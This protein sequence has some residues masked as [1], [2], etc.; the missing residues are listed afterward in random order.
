V[1]VPFV[2]C[3]MVTR[4]RASLARRAVACFANQTWPHRELVIVDDGDQDYRPMLA[5]FDDLGLDI[6]YIRRRSAPGVRLG[7]LRNTSL[8]LAAADWCI[9]WDDD[10]WYHPERI[11]T[12]MSAVAG[13][14]AVLLRWTLMAIEGGRHDGLAFRADAGIATPG[15][16]LHRRDAARYPS[17]ARG[18][19]SVFLREIRSAGSVKVLGR[20]AS[21]LFVRCFHGANTWDEQHFLRRLHRRP[22]DWPSYAVARWWH[23][24]LSRHRACGLDEREWATI[25]E[26]RGDGDELRGDRTESHQ[27][28]KRLSR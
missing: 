28:R 6:R 4:N 24:D 25:D 5:E 27:P 22:I 9:Q 3:L 10:E 15:T 11:A 18:E 2:S 21:H 19:D 13:H 23:H 1:T 7:D 16:V 26:L 20:E 14:T 17:L 8:D 12:Q